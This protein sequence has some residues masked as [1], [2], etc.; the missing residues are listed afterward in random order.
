[1]PF[2]NRKNTGA[3]VEGSVP[4]TAGTVSSR[5]WSVLSVAIAP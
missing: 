2:H 4:N 5:S 1:M 3:V